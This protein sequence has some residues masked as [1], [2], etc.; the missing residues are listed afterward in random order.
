MSDVVKAILEA[1]DPRVMGDAVDRPHDDALFSYRGSTSVPGSFPAFQQMLRGYYE[2][3]CAVAYGKGTPFPFPEEISFEQALAHVESVYGN[4]GGIE[5]A[6]ENARS[7]QNRGIYG[8]YAAIADRLKELHR[9][10][11]VRYVVDKLVNPVDFKQKVALVK[12]IRKTY[13]LPVD[14]YQKKPAEE[15]AS[16]HYAIVMDLMKQLQHSVPAYA[17]SKP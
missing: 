17:Q 1:V 2:Y 16:N 7:G 11:Y 4:Q 13:R 5:G 6:Y 15:L 9:R 10:A 8:A 12:A 14:G 3:H